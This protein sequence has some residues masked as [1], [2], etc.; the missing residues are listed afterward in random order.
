[1]NRP[2]DESTHVLRFVS[3]F[4]PG[5]VLKGT[6]FELKGKNVT[7]EFDV[8]DSTIH[9]VCDQFCAFLIAAGWMVGPGTIVYDKQAGLK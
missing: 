2:V 9:D 3:E 8:M 4:K 6:S 7:F 5:E 1:M